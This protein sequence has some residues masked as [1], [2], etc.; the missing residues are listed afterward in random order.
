M[1]E[2][3]CLLAEATAMCEEGKSHYAISCR[4]G[5]SVLPGGANARL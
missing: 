2:I 3:L 5:V 4:T 1:F